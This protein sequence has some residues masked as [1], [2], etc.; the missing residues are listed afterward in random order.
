MAATDRKKSPRVSLGSELPPEEALAEDAASA[1]LPEGE[2]Q[3]P[4]KEPE[5]DDHEAQLEHDLE[6][7]S[8][9]A[10]KADEYL[11]LA[12]RTKADFE[13][14]RKRAAR[15]AAAA[16]QRGIVKLARELLP[17]VD[18]L[19]R[20]VAAAQDAPTSGEDGAGNLV[21][22]LKLVHTGVIAALARVGIEPYSPEGE[23]FD[24]QHHEAVAQ[25]PVEGAEPG[26]IVEVYQ[27][28][29]RLGDG[30]VL[31][32]ARVVVAA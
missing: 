6:E 26:T 17:A 31:R 16:Q 25:L 5:A 29:Y 4:Q 23:R 8:A 2:Q 27:R 18:D 14:Y 24:P 32:P 22:G 7:L 13:N 15:E 9:R 10:G 3:E 11:E 21:S 20:A 12:Q 30:L 19:D 1:P 28:G